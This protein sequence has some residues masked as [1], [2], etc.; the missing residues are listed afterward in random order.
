MAL[1]GMPVPGGFDY[2]VLG[3]GAAGSIVAARLATACP[4]RTVLLVEAGGAISPT[5]ETVW[6][7]KQ[8]VLVSRNPDLEWA[9]APCPSPSSARHSSSACAANTARSHRRLMAALKRA[10]PIELVP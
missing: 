5:G 4:D 1:Q 9:I 10:H 6:D 8:W 3:A 2:A 7:P